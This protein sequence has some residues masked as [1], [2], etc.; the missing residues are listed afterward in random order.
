M[1]LEETCLELIKK[2]YD[3]LQ[4][5]CLSLNSEFMEFRDTTNES[6]KPFDKSTLAI[7]VRRRG[8]Y[9]LSATWTYT[10]FFRTKDGWQPR[11]YEI[12]KGREPRTP[13]SRINKRAKEWEMETLWETEQKVTE[14]RKELKVMKRI[15]ADLRLLEKTDKKAREIL[16]KHF[17]G[18][19]DE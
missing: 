19:T 4:H 16:G 11:T 15:V 18:N 8:D 12:N 14:I 2:R 3:E 13:Y 6:L 17:E 7:R 9:S 1:E 10:R 5:A